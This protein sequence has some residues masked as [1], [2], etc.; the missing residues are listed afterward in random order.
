MDADPDLLSLLIQ[1]AD[2]ALRGLV[3]DVLMGEG[4]AVYEAATEQEGLDLGEHGQVAYTGFT[5][6]PA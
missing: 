5:N 2:P 4:Y 6:L 3:R 1:E